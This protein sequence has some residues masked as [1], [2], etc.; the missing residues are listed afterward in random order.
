MSPATKAWAVL[1]D[2]TFLKPSPGDAQLLSH[3]EGGGVILNGMCWAHGGVGS[4]VLAPRIARISSLARRA[5]RRVGTPR[6]APAVAA[7]TRVARVERRPRQI[8]V[9]ALW[10]WWRRRQM[11]APPRRWRCRDDQH[12]Q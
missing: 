5:R 7:H 1:R 3:S 2:P 8:G 11:G 4:H 9:L 6:A 12:S 10:L